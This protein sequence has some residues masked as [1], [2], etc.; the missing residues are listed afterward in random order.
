[1]LFGPQYIDP[2]VDIYKTN[3]TTTSLQVKIIYLSFFVNYKI[4]LSKTVE[5]RPTENNF[6]IA[7]F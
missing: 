1:M 6:T 4:Y 7:I 5:L 2:G 3:K